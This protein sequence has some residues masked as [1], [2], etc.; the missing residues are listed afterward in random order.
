MR[1]G[2]DIIAGMA[3]G[4]VFRIVSNAD[5]AF[6]RL[7]LELS[8]YYLVGFEPEPGDRDAKP[9]KI[10]M[11]VRR[12]D[13]AIRARREFSV[14]ADTPPPAT[15][16]LVLDTLR[17]PLLASDIRIGL[18][19]YTFQDPESQKVKVILSADLDR[20]VDA[21][22]RVSLG[23][24]LVD[25]K[26]K[27]TASQLEK[28][29]TTPVHPDTRRQT[30]VG[31]ALTMPG[32]YTLKL[33]AVDEDGRRGSVER[34]F[35]AQLNAFGGLHVTDLLIADDSKTMPG[36]AG[37][38]PS[39]DAKFT[40]DEVHGYVELFSDSAATLRDA[41]V[42]I[43]VAES[44][45][46]KALAGVTA[47]FQGVEGGDRRRVAEAAVPIGQLGAGH[48]VLRAAV[49]VNGEK[50]GQ[51]LRPFEITR[52]AKTAAAAPPRN[53]P[54]P[55]S[56]GTIPAPKPDAFDRSSV[57][58]PQVVGFFLDRLNDAPAG[59]TGELRPA[60]D[61][62]KAGRF[63][64]AMDALAGA[65][66]DQLATVFL[67][68]LVLFSRGELNPAANKFREAL[69]IDSA[70]SPATFYLG[71]CYA[72]GGRD[73]EAAGALQMSLIAES[74]APIVYMTLADTF[75][76]LRDYDQAIQTLQEGRRL[77]PSDEQLAARLAAVQQR[78]K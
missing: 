7:A 3:R 36:S 63:T 55:A 29:M 71:A 42:T 30:Y 14:A 52:P 40:G 66:D 41:T 15:D 67:K 59:N 5:F 17:S 60:I 56:P 25:D 46:S 2:L 58:T 24:V 68:G 31:A 39:V 9:H 49:A 54:K 16:T 20:S 48:Y 37:L 27:V 78:Q 18:T 50:V 1:E 10:K 70:F 53:A 8:G 51:V 19:T 35:T 45:A 43:E 6:R 65:G 57:L 69:K 77:W 11:D 12:K 61:N 74:S 38:I 73:R 62:V 23:Y 13:I 76:R 32:V 34:T 21:G 28:A 72:A 22:Q 64:E 44:A 26:G 4:D 33:A 47:Q 75:M